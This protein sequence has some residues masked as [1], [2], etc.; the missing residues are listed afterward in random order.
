MT[1]V[2]RMRARFATPLPLALAAAVAAG[3]ACSADDEGDVRYEPSPPAV[4]DRMLEMGEAGSAEV[5]YDLG[6]G[7]GRLVVAAARDFGV[8]RAIGVEIDAELIARSRANAEEA[9]VADRTR[10]VQADLFEYDFSDADLVTLFLLPR[11][12]VQLRPRLLEE[13]EPG[14][15]VVSHEHDMGDWRPD[16]STRVDG[17]RIHLWII[18]ARAQG[19]WTGESDGTRYRLALQQLYQGVG[20]TLHVDDRRYVLEDARLRGP[21][22]RFTALPAAG[23]DADALVFDGRIDGDTLTG[24]LRGGGEGIRVRA[25]R[26]G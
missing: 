18:P 20:G 10:F 24:A 22:L 13:L 12:N 26:G 4:V 23:Y 17:H 11:L 6:S 2:Q 8:E 25:Q 14:T 1:R 7:D 9:G 16:A 5:M 21:R 15:R 19:R 3:P